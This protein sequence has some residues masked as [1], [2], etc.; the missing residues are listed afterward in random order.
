MECVEIA[1]RTSL[2]AEDTDLHQKIYRAGQCAPPGRYRQLDS[3]R[4]VLLEEEDVLPASL[5]GHV[6]YYVKI[7]PYTTLENSEKPLSS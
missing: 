6:A 1:S 7:T 3:N 5:D 4:E 2:E